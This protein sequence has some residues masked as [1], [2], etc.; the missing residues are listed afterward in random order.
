MALFYLLAKVNPVDLNFG[1]T[2]QN[3][4]AN[5]IIFMLIPSI[6]STFQFL[7]LEAQ[8]DGNCIDLQYHYI[9]GKQL[10]G[11]M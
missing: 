4:H 10:M 7:L 1:F 5:W 2:R 6:R 3:F 9:Y 11:A 8:R